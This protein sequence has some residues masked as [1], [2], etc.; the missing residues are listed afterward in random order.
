V[1]TSHDELKA[2]DLSLCLLACLYI[3]KNPPE[4][5]AVRRSVGVG[6]KS[7]QFP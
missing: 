5:E 3:A 4:A 6:T 2:G 1:Q 7:F